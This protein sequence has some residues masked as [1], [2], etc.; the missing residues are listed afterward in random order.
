M[1]T[2]NFVLV[3]LPKRADSSESSKLVKT[4]VDVGNLL[5]LVSVADSQ[6]L[7][8][9]RG[10]GKTHVLQ[11]LAAK[12]N[13]RGDIGIYV[14]L[15]S[16]GSTGGIYG[17]P[18]LPIAERGTR[19]LMDVM[20]AIHENLAD[21]CLEMRYDSDQDFD[22]AVRALNEFAAAITEVR[23]VGD[24]ER[25]VKK[26][27][28]DERVRSA[29]KRVDLG[30][31]GGRIAFG[32]SDG[33]EQSDVT[34]MR[35]LERG[36][37]HHRVHFGSVTRVLRKL[38]RAWANRR[39]WI[40]LDEWS[41][42]PLDLQPLLADMLRRALF[43]LAQVTVKIGAIAHRSRLQA[44]TAASYIGI[45]L[46]AD[47]STAVDLDALLMLQANAQTSREFLS[48]LIYNHVEALLEEDHSP[49]H[50]AADWR[51]ANEQAG[52]Y[53]G[54]GPRA[55]QEVAFESANAFS[56]L[57]RAA[58]G[59]P[60]DALNILSQAASL[61]QDRRVSVQDVRNAGRSHYHLDK[62]RAI[63]A[64]PSALALLRWI[65]D[66][67]V[68]HRRVRGFLIQEGQGP[69]HALVEDLYDSRVLHIA[70]RGLAMADGPGARF[71][72]YALDYGC[73]AGVEVKLKGLL[74]AADGSF[75]EDPP[76]D[77]R[78]MSNAVL[79]LQHYGYSARE[80]ARRQLR[81]P[82]RPRRDS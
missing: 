37:T 61:A 77:Y 62:E 68:G 43:P 73:Y 10:T 80:P 4:F 70:R 25:E 30:T 9:R 2:T 54:K 26:I 11:Y 20:E 16:A 69:L 74:Q 79:D 41:V 42:I 17:D 36:T 44:S 33:T 39:L 63:E 45:E 76:G 82:R 46:G 53:L 28:T 3:H 50:D 49:G 52:R 67:V 81:R 48:S 55:F 1:R 21:R 47:V 27:T 35:T 18:A 6:V 7:Y 8:G 14:D 75:V 31:A 22:S 56:E 57:G 15:R 72:L 19:L 12:A 24:G 64:N 32:S 40:L 34:E 38:L 5:A 78:E 60:R 29:E 65:V 51:Q 23:V 58:Q 13:E 59:V 66:E 71:T